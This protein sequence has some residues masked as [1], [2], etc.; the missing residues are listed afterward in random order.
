MSCKDKVAVVF[1]ASRGIG[2]QICLTLAKA[3]YLV[4]LSSKSTGSVEHGI[5]PD[6]NSASS[7]IDTVLAEMQAAGGNG[8]AISCDV[9]DETEIKQVIAKV[10]TLYGRIDAMIYNPGAIWWS[11]VERTPLKRYDLM[12]S[13]N[14]RGLYA[15]V[16]ELLPIYRKQRAGRII[17]VAPPIYSRFVRGKTSYAMTK[18]AASVMT[19]GLAVDFERDFTEADVAVSSLWPA[20]ALQSAATKIAKDSELRHP[21]IFADAV[22]AILEAGKTS[23]NGRLLLDEDYLRESQGYADADFDKYALVPNSKPRRI[24]PAKLPDLTV[25]EQDDQ[26]QRIDSSKRAKL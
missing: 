26:G 24:M 14:S 22:L 2:R 12:H 16:M 21:S 1:G 11:A 25:A 13:I 15:A 20:T 3:G 6:P 17:T 10:M 5:V 8:H 4:V 18:I 9:R 19:L 23:V 7:T